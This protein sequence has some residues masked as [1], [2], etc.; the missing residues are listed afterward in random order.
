MPAAA[1]LRGHDIVDERSLA[2]HEAIGRRLEANPTLIE[3]AKANLQRW[4]STAPASLFPAFDEWLEILGPPFAGI[5]S[6][7]ERVAILKKFHRP[8]SSS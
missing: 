1:E 4:G 8:T 2:F 7:A 6:T 3:R 5:L